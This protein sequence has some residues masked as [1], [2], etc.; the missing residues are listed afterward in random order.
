MHKLIITAHPS[1]K[2]FTHVLANTFK[3][4]SIQHG[5]TVEI[6]DLYTTELKQDF[7]RFED[8]REYRETAKVDPTTQSIQEKIAKA[9]ELVFIFPIWWGDM[10]AIMK[11][12]F[13]S[14]FLAGF[15]FRYENG[16]SV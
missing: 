1:T 7:L 9:D 2:G 11:N 15:A 4:L 12:F 5:D 8:I 14:N 6:L 3:E 16:K 10:P 13:D